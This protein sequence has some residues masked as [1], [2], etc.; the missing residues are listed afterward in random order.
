[1]VAFF[2]VDHFIE[3]V[4]VDDDGGVAL[5]LQLR[6]SK[7]SGGVEIVGDDGDVLS[8]GD[9]NGLLGFGDE[10]VA[11]DVLRLELKLAVAHALQ[12]LLE[13]EVDRLSLVVF[14]T[15]VEDRIKGGL[16]FSVEAGEIRV[17][18]DQEHPVFFDGSLFLE[19]LGFLLQLSNDQVDQVLI[20]AG[21]VAEFP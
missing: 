14:H 13:V 8:A 3:T 18:S 10:D 21:P 7:L 16:D 12:V 11:E 19:V 2:F 15:D 1:M 6:D 9:E 17:S 5:F 4:V 20:V